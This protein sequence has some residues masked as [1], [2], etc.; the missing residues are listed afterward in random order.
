MSCHVASLSLRQ[1]GEGGNCEGHQRRKG[2]KV[3]TDP[4]VYSISKPRVVVNT[5]AS[6]ISISLPRY[7]VLLRFH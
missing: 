5:A 1:K 7:M 4:L 3:F 6:G 2:R